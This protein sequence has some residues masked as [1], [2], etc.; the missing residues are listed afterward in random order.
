[1]EK[2]HSDYHESTQSAEIRTQSQIS[3]LQSKIVDLKDDK[4]KMLERLQHLESP[5]LPAHAYFNPKSAK[6]CVCTQKTN[7]NTDAA[8]QLQSYHSRM[9]TLISQ[10]H[11][12]LQLVKDSQLAIKISENRLQEA[13]EI[14]MKRNDYMN[15]WHLTKSTCSYCHSPDHIVSHCSRYPPNQRDHPTPSISESENESQSDDIDIITDTIESKN[16]DNEEPEM[17]IEDDYP[18][19]NPINR[20]LG[21]GPTLNNNN[22]HHNSNSNNYHN[23]NNNIQ[24]Y[25]HDPTSAINVNVNVNIDKPTVKKKYKLKQPSKRPLPWNADQPPATSPTPQPRARAATPIAPPINR[26]I[27]PTL[28]PYQPPQFSA[29]PKRFGKSARC[30]N[31]NVPLPDSSPPQQPAY[32]FGTLRYRKVPKPRTNKP[33]KPPKPTNSLPPSTPHSSQSHHSTSHLT[34]ESMSIDIMDGLR[35]PP[36]PPIVPPQDNSSQQQNTQTQSEQTEDEQSDK[37]VNSP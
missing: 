13:R 11:Q 36:P 3:Y 29:P 37:K 2:L 21:S 8:K 31:P 15:L 20:Q 28:K 16:D 22:N 1:M 7:K 10:E 17:K 19:G 14:V 27:T 23:N 30:I 24:H 6:C 32:T 18:L 25:Q 33:P 5:I 34:T 35:S 12:H 9:K 4:I 26:S